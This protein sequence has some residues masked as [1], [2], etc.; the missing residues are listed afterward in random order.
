MHSSRSLFA[1]CLGSA[2]SM[3]YV[4]PALAQDDEDV[5][6]GPTIVN[7]GGVEV[8]LRSFGRLV[9]DDVIQNGNVI[10]ANET[11]PVPGQDVVPRSRRGAATPR[12]TTQL[13]TT[14]RSSRCS[15]RS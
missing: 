2:L 9:A 15:V 8:D 4:P 3:A 1:V 7:K 6:P 14:F 10:L 13:W 12:S 5:E 11:S